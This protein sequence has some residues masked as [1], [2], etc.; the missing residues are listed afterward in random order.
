MVTQLLQTAQSS[1]LLVKVG[2]KYVHRFLRV[3]CPLQPLESTSA[4]VLEH[5]LLRNCTVSSA[6]EGFQQRVR[7][8][9]SEK[10]SS[11]L[12]AEK[13]I[14][15]DRAGS[16]STLPFTCDVHTTAGTHSKV[17]EGLMGS[18]VSALINCSLSLQIRANL[19]ASRM[20]LRAVIRKRLVPV[21]GG[22]SKE[23][24]NYKQ[25]VLH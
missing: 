18:K 5:A 6:C 10:A 16:W 21:R 1:W 13:S 2:I 22:I 25:A 3:A 20:C 14:A 4:D 9:C 12:L 24:N 23:A 7:C 11:N 19:N 8:V 15:A 17:F